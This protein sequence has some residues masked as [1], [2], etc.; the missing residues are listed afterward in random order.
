VHGLSVSLPVTRRITV[1][2]VAMRKWLWPA[3]PRRQVGG[4][5][6]STNAWVAVPELFFTVKVTG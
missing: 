2:S 3:G 6:V 4:W 5:T 1:M